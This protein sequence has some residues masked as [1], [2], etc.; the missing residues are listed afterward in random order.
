MAHF[1]KTRVNAAT[2]TDCSLFGAGNMRIRPGSSERDPS[3]ANNFWALAQAAVQHHVDPIWRGMLAVTRPTELPDLGMGVGTASM[4]ADIEAAVGFNLTLVGPLVDHYIMQLGQGMSRRLRPRFHTGLAVFSIN[5][6]PTLW[7]HLEALLTGY[8]GTATRQYCVSR[9]GL[10]SVRVTIPDIATAQRIWSP[11]RRDGTNY[12]CRRHFQR[13][14]HIGQDGQIHYTST[15]QGYSA[16]V[17]S[18]LTPV[19]VTS[20]LR[21]GIT[22]CSFFR[23]NYTEGG[24]AINT[25]LQA[26]LNSADAM[27]SSY[28]HCCQACDQKLGHS[29]KF[30]SEDPGL[31]YMVPAPRR[32]RSP[33]TVGTG[34]EECGR[35]SVPE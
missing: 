7:R 2:Q 24:L 8:G 26:T 16:V 23:Q 15:F 4:S 32:L 35:D 27:E 11:A 6:P 20:H 13:A 5:V 19:V 9:A 22:T 33:T 34:Q 18:S 30:L 14:R 3:N 17:V 28:V 25:S 21:T 29:G 31:I 12:L 1:Y 10:R